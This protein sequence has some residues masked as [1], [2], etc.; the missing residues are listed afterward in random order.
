MSTEQDFERA[1]KG[2]IHEHWVLF[3]VEG[4]ALVVLG[5]IAVVVPPL[6]TVAYTI[7]IGWVC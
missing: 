5:A 3:L 6:A 7:L 1:A 2:A 4:I